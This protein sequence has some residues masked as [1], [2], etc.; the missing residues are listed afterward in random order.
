M[1]HINIFIEKET[2]NRNLNMLKRWQ[3]INLEKGI[4]E[5]P[6]VLI[7][8]PKEVGKTTL[9]QKIGRQYNAVYKTLEK[10]STLE[11]ARNNPRSFIRTRQSLMIIDE[12]QKIPPLF[13]TIQE[14]ILS[15]TDSPRFLL[16]SSWSTPSLL[17][18][19]KNIKQHFIEYQIRPLT[20]GERNEKKPSFLEN[21]FD[22]SFPKKHYDCNQKKVINYAMQGGFPDAIT[23]KNTFARTNWHQAYL[24]KLLNHELKSLAVV[25]KHRGMEE[26]TGIL[27]GWSSRFI[28]IAAIGENINLQ[29]LTI[30]SYIRLLQRLYFV[31][32]LSPWKV[33]KYPGAAKKKKI[34][35][36]DSGLMTALL[37]WEVDALFFEK[38][39]LI[40][41]IKTFLFNEIRTQIDVFSPQYNLYYYRDR[42][43]R[44]I[45]F[46]IE[47][48][49]GL[50]LGIKVKS[51]SGISPS[52]FSQLKF[53]ARRILEKQPF[54][55]IVLYPGQQVIQHERNL[56]AVPISALW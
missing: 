8:G 4:K 16:I 39:K 33:T 50:I 24:V 27:A 12:I 29:R 36:N 3:G 11:V 49:D 2:S 28:D 43:K 40:Q 13:Q 5:F 48:Q 1:G 34:F 18:F 37:G 53:F 20:H 23:K 9:A 42:Q 14:Y 41:V 15:S 45:D 46:V 25:K 31:E 51:G 10:V 30:E 54:I 47:R 7:H 32:T 55:G 35:I 56:W 52:S 38:E 19:K 44:E 22:T 26:L 21:A 17:A 6:V